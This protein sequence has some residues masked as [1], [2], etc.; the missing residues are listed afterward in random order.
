MDSSAGNFVVVSDG[1]ISGLATEPKKL[2]EP[3]PIRAAI[4]LAAVD[5]WWDSRNVPI[6]GEG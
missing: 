1:P 2:N 4:F 5:A 3:D 6:G